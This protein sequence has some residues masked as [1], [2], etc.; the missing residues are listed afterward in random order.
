MTVDSIV[1]RRSAG[2]REIVGATVISCGLWQFLPRWSLLYSRSPA[3]QL[4]W[5]DSDVHQSSHVENL[6][7]DT[8]CS[9]TLKIKNK[10]QILDLHL[11][12]LGLPYI[13]SLMIPVT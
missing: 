10:S 2:I 4:E 5:P 13:S 1:F 8:H 3:V 9:V 12:D 6:L 7:V 11:H